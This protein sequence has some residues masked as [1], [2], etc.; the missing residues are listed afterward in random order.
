[1]RQF[2]LLLILFSVLPIHSYAQACFDPILEV[3]DTGIVLGETSN[4][5]RSEPSTSGA[6]VGGIEGG[7]R[8]T[9][10]ELG[11]CDNGIRWINVEAENGFAGWT[12]ESVSDEAFV[13]RIVILDTDFMILGEGDIALNADGTKLVVGNQLYDAQDL[14]SPST[15]LPSNGS[16]IFSPIDPDLL[17]M[18]VLDSKFTL[19]DIVDMSIIWSTT[20]REPSGIGG[21]IYMQ[22]AYFTNDGQYIIFSA[23]EPESSWTIL[24]TDTLDVISIERS[25]Y[26]E[27]VAIVPNSSEFIRYISSIYAPENP[28]SIFRESF[29]TDNPTA[30]IGNGARVAQLRDML[31]MPDGRMVTWDSEG[32][33]DLWST[34]L[35]VIK[36]LDLQDRKSVV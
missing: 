24:D 21:G 20:M 14:N 15:E 23:T 32:V 30:M 8:F 18:Y 16:S 26:G 9:V 4:N 3:G 33:F 7:G 6:V 2:I 1:M 17:F 5:V 34:D 12:A 19:I 11:D 13:R 27:T 22:D 29:M 28:P 10:I 35:R 25:Y 31:M 36:S